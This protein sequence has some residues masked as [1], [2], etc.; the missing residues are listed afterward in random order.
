MTKERTDDVQIRS[1][2]T[3]TC[4]LCTYDE[5]DGCFGVEVIK[6]LKQIH[7]LTAL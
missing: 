6:I 2:L 5:T 3:D 4:I 7:A 1:A